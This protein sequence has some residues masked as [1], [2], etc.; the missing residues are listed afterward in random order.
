[1]DHRIECPA[2]LPAESLKVID[3][4]SG[5]TAFS[6]NAMWLHS[7]APMNGPPS[8]KG[9]LQ[10]VSTTVKGAKR[11]SRYVW[12][13]R[14]ESPDSEGKWIACKYGETNN[15]VLSKRIDDNASQCTVTYTK[16]PQGRSDVDIHCDW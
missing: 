8:R 9:T 2:K 13:E 3:A 10:D 14:G 1:M 6:D 15:V 5:W 12:D 7:A 16:N 4:P 11:I